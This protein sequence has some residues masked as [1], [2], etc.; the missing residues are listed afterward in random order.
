M[1]SLASALKVY[2]PIE[3]GIKE[4]KTGVE[5]YGLLMKCHNEAVK[6][7]AKIS[8]NGIDSLF[9]EV[10]NNAESIPLSD[11][12]DFANIKLVVLNN[13]KDIPLFSKKQE[14]IAMPIDAH[15]LHKGSELDE[16]FRKGIYLLSIKDSN[17]WVKKRIGFNHPVY[18]MDLLVVENGKVMN[19]PVASYGT[20][21]SEPAVEVISVSVSKKEVK[22]LTM[23]RS[24]DST[25]KTT[26]LSIDNQ[27]NIIISNIA[28]FTPDDGKLYGDGVI[29]L[30]NTAK[31]TLKDI[32]IKGTYS[33]IDT[34]GYGVS[35]TNV[36][37]LIIDK[38]Y[39]HSK[40]GIFYAS[41]LN[42]VTISDSDINRFDLHCYGRDFTINNCK[43][44]GRSN[45][46]SSLYGYLKYDNCEFEDADPVGL[47]QDYNA[48]TPFELYFKN[49]T[50][51]MT[52]NHNCVLR[53]NG[54]SDYENERPE[55]SGKCLPNIFL[56]HCKINFSPDVKRW[57]LIITGVIKYTKEISYLERIRID[58]LIINGERDFDISSSVIQTQKTLDIQFNRIIINENGSQSA[59][60]LKKATLGNNAHMKCNGEKVEPFVYVGGYKIVSVHCLILVVC[61]LGVYFG[62]Y[63][64]YF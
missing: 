9:I 4:A 11:Y 14:S 35:I 16:K 46:Y 27:Y 33:Q 8:Y 56:K 1:L 57:F 28:V 37:D 17:P 55:L 34:Y 3:Y 49:C 51:N 10:P 32:I 24:P 39:G 20:P 62:I 60:E 25:F 6:S 31:V 63:K 48:N 41:S 7:N 18:R 58:D 12:V 54:L 59:Y 19:D 15:L 64:L 44:T 40:W 53:V 26:L 52:E 30:H 21:F 22:N 42:V 29:S 13:Q 45:P 23:Y 2:N 43:F 61:V 5:R 38:M 36:Y 47:R 50:F